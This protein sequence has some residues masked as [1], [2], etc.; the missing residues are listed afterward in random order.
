[1][2]SILSNTLSKVTLVAAL[3]LGFMNSAA[4]AAEFR[5]KTGLSTSTRLNYNDP[6]IWEFK[7]DPNALIWTPAGVNGP[8]INDDVTI[9]GEYKLYLT[10][11]SYS[12]DLTFETPLGNNYSLTY[13]DLNG[14]DFTANANVVI[15]NTRNN[16][17]AAIVLTGGNFY[18]GG[19]IS[20]ATPGNPTPNAT[21][22][23]AST[24]SSNDK[25]TAAPQAPGQTTPGGTKI[26]PLP[27]EL[28]SFTA[29]KRNG[30]VAL[31]WETASEQNNTGFEVQS[32]VDGKN[33]E[34]VAFVAS[35][36]GNATS[37]QRYAYSHKTAGKEGLVY[38]RL[39]QVDMD[40]TVEY[41]T[42]KVVDLGRATASVNKGQLVGWLILLSGC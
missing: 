9:N 1:M 6:S 23:I 34:A 10:K 24:V 14:F 28:V 2:R 18:Y 27:V 22:M 12:K 37:L 35:K 38:Y 30:E 42:A 39:K 16:Q 7:A 17:E 21:T 33:F 15:N 11:A 20:Y 25:L 26:T 5:T 3:G 40:G 29:A 4:E 19:T 31:A 36:N 32:S 8:G 13:L 41:F